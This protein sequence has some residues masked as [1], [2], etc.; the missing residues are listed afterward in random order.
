MT[1]VPIPSENY[2]KNNN[3][4]VKTDNSCNF[5]SDRNPTIFSG[6]HFGEGNGFIHMKDVTCTGTETDI[7]ICKFTGWT[8]H[9]CT[10][11]E[12]IGID[13]GMLSSSSIINTHR[14]QYPIKAVRMLIY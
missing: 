9:D 7:G 3:N 10:H 8:V 1:K 11:S 6:G 4:F 14:V 5:Q 12:D 2:L 13:C